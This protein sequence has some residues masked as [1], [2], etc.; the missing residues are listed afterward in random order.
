MPLKR[1]VT[2]QHTATRYSIALDFRNADWRT[3]S[4]IVKS[5]VQRDTSRS[6]QWK[7]RNIRASI[8]TMQRKRKTYVS[9]LN[10]PISFARWKRDQSCEHL[11]RPIKYR[12]KGKDKKRKKTKDRKRKE[13]VPH[14]RTCNISFALLSTLFVYACVNV[15]V[16]VH[17]Y[18]T[19]L[20]FYSIILMQQSMHGQEIFLL[21]IALFASN[22]AAIT[23]DIVFAITAR[24]SLLMRANRH[25]HE[26][27]ECGSTFSCRQWEKWTSLRNELKKATNASFCW[28]RAEELK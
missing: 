3:S 8:M 14:I 5:A 20:S 6:H 18:D 24:C 15:C 21:S 28:K 22:R 12:Y 11:P 9:A 23:C 13:N 17:V 4:L 10:R 2:Y 25:P 26:S 16:W 1:E 19:S 7:V 27:G